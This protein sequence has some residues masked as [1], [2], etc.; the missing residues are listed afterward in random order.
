[1]PPAILFVCTGNTCRSVMAHYY[2]QAVVEGTAVVESAGVN[3]T[4]GSPA[5]E[6][7]VKV[8][9]EQG[10]S[11]EGVRKHSSSL[12]TE[13][14]M[15]AASHVVCMAVKHKEAVLA[16]F[17]HHSGKVHTLLSDLST[18]PDISVEDPVRMSIETY[19]ERFQQMVPSLKYLLSSVQ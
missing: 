4:E 5:A 15:A 19:R 3:A 18:K 1:M 6:N 7:A 11:L 13:E 14:K 9:E 2:M 10:V 8:L 12:V 17:P 16:S